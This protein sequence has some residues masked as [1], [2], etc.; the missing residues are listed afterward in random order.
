MIALNDLRERYRDFHAL[1]SAIALMNWDRQVLMPAGG[2]PARTAHQLALTKMRHQLLTSDETRRLIERAESEVD[3]QTLESAEIAALRKDFESAAKLPASLVERKAT[4]SNDAYEVWKRAKAEN[5]FDMLAP[6]YAELFEIARETSAA[7]GDAE[8]PYDN[9]IDLYEE[10]AKYEDARR[11]F[12]AIRDPIIQ[13]VARIREEG[14]E[15]DDSILFGDWDPKA[16]RAFA[17]D[18]AGKIGFDF[19]RGRLDVA[20]NAFC[21]GTTTQDVRMTT[22]HS[23]HIKGI[24]S[25]SLHE[26]GH[27]LYEQNCPR[28]WDGTAISGGASLAV[29]ESQSRLWENIVGRSRPFWMHFFPLLEKHVPAVGDLG[30]EG[31]YRAY[32]KVEPTFIRV[33]ADELT[34]NLHILVRFELEVELVTKQ[35]E[36]KDIPE[37]WNEKYRRYLGIVPPTDTLG[38]LQDVHWS[39]GS[40]GYF[41]TYAMGNLIGGHMWQLLRE[42]VSDV[43]GKMARGEFGEILGWLTEKVYRHGRRYS[44]RELVQNVCGAYL[45]PKPWMDYATA[46]YESLYF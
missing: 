31:F 9:L 23:E 35:I 14:R 10:G 26:M 2:A 11:M 40:I 15:N 3:P 37:A 27:G 20:P 19:N 6:Y 28:E 29:H 33:G 32:S 22:R 46:K 8:H 45:D 1:E 39:R 12:D 41:P 34:Y 13:L 21:N 38:C 17:Q 7:L 25:S 24:V 42:D 43:D 16:L 44:P 36:V 30:H 18:A 5:R 4:V